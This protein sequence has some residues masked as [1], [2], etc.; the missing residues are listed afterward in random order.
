MARAKKA[1]KAVLEAPTAE[2]ARDEH[3]RLLDSWGLPINA[4]A[5]VEALEA[6]G[7]PDPNDD[8]KAW[9]G[10]KPPAAVPLPAPAKL[11]EAEGVMPGEAT[12]AGETS[13]EGAN[14]D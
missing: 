13:Q 1:V 11:D 9:D 12:D 5:R 7:L 2:Q 4:L 8:P 3:G 6:A 10:R 14:N